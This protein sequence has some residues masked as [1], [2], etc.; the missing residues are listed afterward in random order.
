MMKNLYSATYYFAVLMILSVF[1]SITY[2]DDSD[3]YSGGYLGVRAGYSY[4]DNSCGDNAISC[5]K[6]EAGYGIFTGYDFNRNWALELSF[7]DI[8]DSEARYP[9][10]TIDGKLREIDLALKASYPIY[11]E[12]RIYGK[13]G[14]A[15]WDGEVRGGGVELDDSG[16]RPLLGAGFEFPMNDHW[17]TRIEY[18]YIDSLGNRE[19]GRANAHFLGVAFVWNFTSRARAKPVPVATHYPQPVAR[20]PEPAPDRKVVVDEQVGGPLFEFDKAVIRNTAAIDPVARELVDNPALRVSVTGHTD[21]RGA[22][23]YNQR[24]SE[25][26]AHVVAKYLQAKGVSSD[27]LTVYGKGEDQPAADN[28][29]EAGRAK[30]RRVEFV[31]SGAKSL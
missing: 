7:N 27:R 4:N 6:D 16:V 29:T 8:G 17:T 12:T 23:E 3:P 18:Q 2:A 21:S 11:N 24:L 9:G 26:R 15:Y 10:A 22:A 14:A 13:L 30:N 28:Q 25:Q 1:S 19:M 31:I 20:A 5:D